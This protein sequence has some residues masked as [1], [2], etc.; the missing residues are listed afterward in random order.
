VTGRS[1]VVVAVLLVL[2]GSGFVFLLATYGGLSWRVRNQAALEERCESLEEEASRVAEL[3]D[4]LAALRETDRQVRELIG[5]P[6]PAGLP[7]G[8]ESSGEPVGSVAPEGVDRVLLADPVM[9]DEET[10]TR[11]EKALRGMRHSLPW[12]IEGFVTSSYGEAREEG[13]VH[14]GVDIAAP[15]NTVIEA[16]LAG[17]VVEAG[18]HGVYGYL[19]VLD[20]GNGLVTVYGHNA[21]LVVRP[22]DR[23]RAGDAVAFL[24]STGESSA[25]HLHFEVRKDGYALDPLYL[26]KAKS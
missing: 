21:R 14:P 4:E 25:P 16:P 8:G 3:R 6:E 9:P 10:R 7:T 18:W 26:L 13:G 5:I 23:V 22:G 20:H 11:L 19:A 1:L 2:A 24:G 15:R 12:P 17:R